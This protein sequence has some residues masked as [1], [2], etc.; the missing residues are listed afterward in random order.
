[1]GDLELK[2]F[3]RPPSDRLTELL[4]IAEI[5]E[6][7]RHVEGN[8]AANQILLDT[9]GLQLRPVF[10]DD[11]YREA[12]DYHLGILFAFLNQPDRAAEF[13]ERSKT[14][15]NGGGPLVFSEH[16]AEALRLRQR[17]MDG[18]SRGLP[19]I[20]ISSMPRSGSATL[21]QTI[22]ATLDIPVMRISAGDFPNY[23]IAPSW[24]NAFSAGGAVTHDHFSASEFNLQTLI[25]TGIRH[26][27]LLVRDP[28]AAAASF[29]RHGQASSRPFS[30][31]DMTN[32]FMDSLQNGFIPWL[33]EWT[34]AAA[35]VRSPLA[36]HWIRSDR[37]RSDTV[38]TFREMIATL[39]ADFPALE[40]FAGR[41]V[42]VVT[43]NLAAGDEEA[44]REMMDAGQRERIWDSIP[45][46][47]KKLME[48][49]E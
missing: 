45:E 14:L 8:R 34:A 23:H 13:I 32:Y 47:A 37:A 22:S 35:D 17:Q 3:S 43:A 36:I 39:L 4:R 40:G 11:Y 20:L 16:A 27:F 33:S 10:D 5:V 25:R 21:T 2:L 31:D 15:P 7:R 1:M 9:I 28:R 41:D 38:G 30:A 29:A 42:S 24:L 12:L 18:I 46:R 19:Y 49:H 48:L 26:V 44:W 6:Q